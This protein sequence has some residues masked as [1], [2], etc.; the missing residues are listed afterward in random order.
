MTRKI[1]EFAD[2]KN[3]IGP[4]DN[5]G[6]PPRKSSFEDLV[7]KPEYRD[8]IYRFP[9]GT[10]K[11][12]VLPAL[13]GSNMNWMLTGHALGHPGG[14]HL[15]P[16]T[17]AA[18]RSSVFDAAYRWCRENSPELLR[19]KSSPEGYRLLA[20]PLAICWLLVDLPAEPGETPKTVARLLVA[21]AYAGDRGGVAGVGH[22]ISRL[23]QEKDENGALIADPSKPETCPHL[24][25]ERVQAT[26][27]RYPSYS[28]RLGREP[29]PIDDWF[30]RME[31]EE[32]EILR[33]L[34]EVIHIPAPEEEWKLLQNSIPAELVS[35]IRA[36]I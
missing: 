15:H 4:F 30:A 1:I 26:G 10:T 16:R 33:P 25:V 22:L 17:L 9:V 29:S 35:K 32:L 14:R 8:R 28:L 3:L 5:Q 21:S 23:F 34:E 2:P 6:A 24:L 13:A 27:V 12:R 11:V 19:S 7:L 36:V 31:P 18:G 20:D